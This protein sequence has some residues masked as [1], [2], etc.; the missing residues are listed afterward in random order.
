MVEKPKR[1]LSDYIS[2]ATL[3][4]VASAIAYSVAF[5][6]EAGYFSAFNIPLHL[7]QMQLDT[8]LIILITLSTVSWSLF[9][10]IN[11]IAITW[12]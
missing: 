8:V 4:T 11:F 3:I 1:V 6:Y 12:P 7:I 9:S 2:E 10:F 5:L